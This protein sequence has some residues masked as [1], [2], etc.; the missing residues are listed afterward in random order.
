MSNFQVLVVRIAIEPH[1]NADN[2]EIA[3]ILGYSCIVGKGLYKTNDLAIYLPIDSIVPED[4]LE[5]LELV[6]KLK[7]ANKNRIKMIKLRGVPSEGLLYPIN[8]KK[9]PSDVTLKEGDD[10]TDVLGI[11]KYAERIPRK[12]K[13][14]TEDAREEFRK[15][16][17]DDL[18]LDVKFDVE[19]LKKY[20]RLL[21][22]GELVTLTEKIHGTSIR[23]TRINDQIK[24]ST[25][26]LGN[27]GYA[28]KQDETN[29]TYVLMYDKYEREFDKLFAKFDGNVIIFGEIFGRSIQDITYDTD[30]DLRIF[31]IWYD[32]R[33]LNT[34]KVLGALNNTGLE[35]VPILYRGGW[36]EALLDKY[37]SGK[38]LIPTADCMRE[39]IV[40]RPDFERIDTIITGRFDGYDSRVILKVV[41]SE[42]HLRKRGTELE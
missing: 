3:N 10:V 41:S 8:G 11:T 27:L 18:S 35:Y 4:I 25:K 37:V 32:G 33:Y 9:I 40:I 7:G 19:P 22:Y 39:G 17:Y 13:G 16:K 15:T 24:I 6:G 21:N 20:P 36:D 42:Y 38:S 1:P 28:F 2:L 31:D 23:I 5:E 26:R 14:K 29:S 12:F 30:P 34:D